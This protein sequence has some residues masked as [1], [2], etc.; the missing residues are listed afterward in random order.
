MSQ[1]YCGPY[2]IT[3][4]INNQA[5]QLLL[6]PHLKVHNVFHVILLKVYVPSPDHILNDEQILM[7]S[8][9]QVELHLECILN[10]SERKPR[11]QNIIEHS[12]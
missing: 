11:T 5:Y 6:P 1:A 9:G 12:I 8:Q 10:T 7:P 2:V 3:K 4:W